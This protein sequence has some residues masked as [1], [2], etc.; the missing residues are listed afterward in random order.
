MDEPDLFK[1]EEPE[2]PLCGLPL[3]HEK[4][5][6]DEERREQA[7]DRAKFE[8]L[9]WSVDPQVV[10]SVTGSFSTAA[11]RDVDDFGDAPEA[12]AR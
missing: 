3:P 1:D 5:E 9:D 8:S 10:H 4:V 12:R 2:C 6:C 11:A 7:L